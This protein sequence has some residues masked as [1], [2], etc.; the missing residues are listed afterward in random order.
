[1]FMF[2]DFL[3]ENYVKM[4]TSNISKRNFLTSNMYSP[5]KQSR[6]IIWNSYS[7]YTLIVVK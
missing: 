2:L 6:K 7:A 3:Q 1:M 5:H 4:C